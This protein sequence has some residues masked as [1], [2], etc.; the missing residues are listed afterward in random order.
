MSLL[1]QRTLVTDPHQA[2]SAKLTTIAGTTPD[3]TG[4]RAGNTAL[5]DLLVDL[6]AL[7]IVTDSTT[8]A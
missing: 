4:V 3:V 1:T 8:D 7:G 6:A 5:A 2:A